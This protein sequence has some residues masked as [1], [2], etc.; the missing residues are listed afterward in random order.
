M[1]EKITNDRE[2]YQYLVESIRK[3]PTQKKL[4]KRM[5]NAEFKSVKYTN[6]SA[7]IAAVHQGQKH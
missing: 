6:F 3:F 1:G 7:G 2:S 5:E 4:A